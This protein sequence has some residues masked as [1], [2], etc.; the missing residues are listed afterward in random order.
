MNPAALITRVRSALESL[1]DSVRKVLPGPASQASDDASAQ[2]EDHGEG[3]VQD[4]SG[5]NPLPAS[6][7]LPEPPRRESGLR[8]HVGLSRVGTVSPRTV[9]ADPAPDG[10]AFAGPHVAPAS[11]AEAAPPVAETPAGPATPP[12]GRESAGGFAS[13]S[14]SCRPVPRAAAPLAV[15]NMHRLAQSPPARRPATFDV[16]RNP[17]PEFDETVEITDDFFGHAARIINLKLRRSRA[18]EVG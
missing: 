11:A 2:A 17:G 16:G 9:P 14:A 12:A 3:V 4:Q 7:T 10:E 6:E 1:L 8:S 18:G 5:D 13:I 15:R